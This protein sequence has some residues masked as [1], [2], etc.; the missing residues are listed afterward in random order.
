MRNEQ[1]YIDGQ[2][3]DL[4]DNTKITLNINSNIFTDIS[5]IVS[6]FTYT[7]KLPNTVRNQRIIEHSDLPGCETLYPRLKH[8]ARYIRNGVELIS[9]ARAVLLSTGESIEIVMV[10]GNIR[11]IENISNKGLNDL[12]YDYN[13]WTGYFNWEKKYCVAQPQYFPVINYGFTEADTTVYYHPTVSVKWILDRIA[14]DAG[15]TFNYDGRM[16]EM[17]EKLIIPLLSR[18]DS[19]LFAQSCAI[20]L[21]VSGHTIDNVVNRERFYFEHQEKSNYYGRI[22]QPTGTT[23]PADGY[24]SFPKNGKVKLTGKIEMTLSGS[25]APV[26]PEI[27][28]YNRNWGNSGSVSDTETVLTIASSTITKTADKTYQVIFDFKDEE[29]SVLKN[30]TLPEG[31]RQIWFSVDNLNGCSISSLSGNINLV[32]MA[33]EVILNDGSNNDGRFWI[34]PNLPNIKQIDFMKA[35][36]SMLGVFAIEKGENII[37]FACADDI[38]FNIDKAKDWTK[39]VVASYKSNK[40]K[41]LTYVLDGYAQRNI[42]SY[43][44]D[45]SIR[46]SYNSFYEISDETLDSEADVITLPF[47]ATDMIGG[48]CSIPLYSYD[49]D[50]NLSYSKG[51]PRIL[52]LNSSN[53]AT[54]NGLEWAQLLNSYYLKYIDAINGPHVITEKIEIS[55]IDLKGIDVSIP[56]Y[57][58]QYGRYYAIISIKAENTGICECKLLQLNL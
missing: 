27:V 29:T 37:G 53:K 13:Q 16:S 39:R 28:V 2:L 25:N 48:V 10:W 23:T 24:E 33:E 30:N 3:V 34:V 12:S 35:I 14:K 44:S 9:N 55:D 8:S 4:D 19:E 54:F 38:F 1:L 36:C 17:I 43:K 56:V 45:D 32:N 58:A 18:N 50:S 41:E 47:V 6:N 5:K 46:G 52:L 22:I 31:K 21:K 7:I 49:K 26:A 40:P 11:N 57:L 42:V 20:N 51:E 15:I